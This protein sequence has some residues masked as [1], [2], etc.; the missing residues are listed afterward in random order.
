MPTGLA[1]G[2]L[3][4]NKKP[5]Q[6]FASL[7]SS[8]P[9]LAPPSVVVLCRCSGTLPLLMAGTRR[10]MTVRHVSLKAGRPEGRC[11][12]AM[13]GK[14]P[15]TWLR[16][17]SELESACNSDR[18]RMQSKS[19]RALTIVGSS[20]VALLAVNGRSFSFKRIGSRPQDVRHHRITDK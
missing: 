16:R 15:F 3:A 10:A 13:T 5:G 20:V 11:E 12:L 8:W 7:S 18:P 17:R 2:S 14:P 6:P 9:G 19:A 4:P 1:L